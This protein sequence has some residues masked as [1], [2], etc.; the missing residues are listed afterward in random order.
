MKAKILT[1]PPGPKAR[2]IIDVMAR[3]CYDS[4][5]TYPLVVSGGEGCSIF[6]VDGNSFLDFTSNIGTCPLG[7]SHPAILRVLSELSKNSAHKIAGQDFYCNEH[8]DLSEQVRSIIPSGFKSFFT[9]SGAEAVENAIKIARAHTGRPGVIAFGGGYHG[10]T[11]MTLSL[12]GKVNPYSAGMGLMPG[13][14]YRAQYPCALHG[15]SVDAAM[16]SIERIFKNTFADIEYILTKCA[17]NGTRF[18]I[19]CYDIGHLYTLAHFADRG[20]VKPPFFVQSVFGLLGGIG[21]HPEDVAHMRR[22]ADRLFGEEYRWSVLGAGRNQMPVAAIA[23]EHDIPFL[24]IRAVS[25]GNGDPLGLP[26]SQVQFFV[27]RQLAGNNAAALI[28]FIAATPCAGSSA[29]S[30]T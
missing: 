6:D 4:T 14:V 16:A 7:Y 30:T 12:T 27:Y 3:N 18:E 19:E 13:G 10:R 29:A 26:G 15:V 28:A 8:A 5:F 1:E 17:E 9:N 11:M 22:T 23:A 24:G 20:I 25:D 2:K 21:A